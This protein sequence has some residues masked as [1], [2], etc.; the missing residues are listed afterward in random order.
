MTNGELGP[1]YGAQWRSW[2]ATDQTIDQIS[3]GHRTD[4]RRIQI[5]AG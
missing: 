3:R 1:V 2:Q 5:P 4:Q